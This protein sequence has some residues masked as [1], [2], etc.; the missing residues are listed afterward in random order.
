M[1]IKVM[2]AKIKN[3]ITNDP[4]IKLISRHKALLT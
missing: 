4:I 2:L 1:K 3:K